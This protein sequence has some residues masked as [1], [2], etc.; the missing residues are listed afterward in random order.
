MTDLPAGQRPRLL[1]QVRQAI[2]VR[3]L[4]LRTEQAYVHWI[5]R[6]ILFHGKRHPRE[7]GAEEVQ[8][9]LTWLAL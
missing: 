6:Y 5:K 8:V 1:D 2:R 4:S 3:H 9:F 7:M